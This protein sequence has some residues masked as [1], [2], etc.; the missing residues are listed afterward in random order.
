[1]ARNLVK[2]VCALFTVTAG[3]S[4]TPLGAVNLPKKVEFKSELAGQTF[5]FWIEERGDL[6]G[7]FPADP[8]RGAEFSIPLPTYQATG[9]VQLDGRLWVTLSQSGNPDELHLFEIEPTLAADLPVLAR[10]NGLAAFGLALMP[11]PFL[12]TH[13][14]MAGTAIAVVVA[15]QIHRIYS[16]RRVAKAPPPVESFDG[17]E[18]SEAGG[19]LRVHEVL[20]AKDGLLNDVIVKDYVGKLFSLR[21]GF[22]VNESCRLHLRGRAA[23]NVIPPR[24]LIRL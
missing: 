13:P 16:R 3:A 6:K 23:R 7:R 22:E 24:P 20:N 8:V 9:F 14:V 21:T 10:V 12:G 19:T 11:V 4:N 1:M 18:R 15:Q 17:V 5:A 2:L